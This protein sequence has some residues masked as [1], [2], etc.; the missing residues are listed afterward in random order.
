MS[1]RENI[2]L[3]ARSPFRSK[4]YLMTHAFDI[5]GGD[6]CLFVEKTILVFFFNFHRVI[7]SFLLSADQVWSS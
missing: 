6:I 2:R 7:Y 5:K 3:I 4:L 1:T